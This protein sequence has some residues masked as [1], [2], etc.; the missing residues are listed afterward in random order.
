M[1]NGLRDLINESNK[2]VTAMV[3]RSQDAESEESAENSKKRRDAEYSDSEQEKICKSF[4]GVSLSTS[5][6]QHSP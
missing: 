3:K 5:L 6:A 1:I 2:D 4:K